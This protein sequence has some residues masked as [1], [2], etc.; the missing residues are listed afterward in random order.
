MIPLHL[1]SN[2]RER[3]CLCFFTFNFKP[4]PVTSRG[5]DLAIPLPASV[6]AGVGPLW[7]VP[8][9]GGRGGACG[10]ITRESGPDAQLGVRV[11]LSAREAGSVP[12]AP[13]AGR[14]HRALRIE[15]P[16]GGHGARWGGH[17]AHEPV[18]VPGWGGQRRWWGPL[19][20]RP[21][22]PH[23]WGLC[24]LARGS[25]G[26]ASERCERP[27]SAQKRHLRVGR[28]GAWSPRPPG[29]RGTSPSSQGPPA[30]V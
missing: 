29:F 13:G 4:L 26:P 27:V 15:V 17:G 23:C 8:G 5:F 7:G 30:W 20:G 3:N 2:E 28:R 21:G 24:L 22:R 18:Q 16:T 10:P 11:T 14:L 19:V 12:S 9:D 6:L 1:G 25:P